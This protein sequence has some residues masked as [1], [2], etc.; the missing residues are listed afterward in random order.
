MVVDSL[1]RICW[2]APTVENLVTQ[3]ETMYHFVEL[4][5]EYESNIDKHLC[6]E[7]FICQ[8]QINKRMCDMIDK[9][10][11]YELNREAH[12]IISRGKHD[13]KEQLCQLTDNIRTYMKEQ[14]E[15][16]NKDV[17]EIKKIIRKTILIDKCYYKVWIHYD[18]YSDFEYESSDERHKYYFIKIL[19]YTE[20]QLTTPD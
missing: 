3:A 4:F 17:H 15:A 18:Y 7:F 12:K 9:L 19:G 8:M 20:E 11:E 1:R 2:T 10:I 6:M 13:R 14:D 16:L 5:N